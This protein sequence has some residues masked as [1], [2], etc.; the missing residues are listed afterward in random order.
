MV[1][2]GVVW[3]GV[4]GLRAR[5]CPS[6]SRPVVGITGITHTIK[7]LDYPE[8]R[9]DMGEKGHTYGTLDVSRLNERLGSPTLIVLVVSSHG[10][11]RIL[12]IELDTFSA[13]NLILF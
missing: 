3:C 5:N 7:R 12:R 8:L 13:L 9:S 2:C 11:G 1:W 4:V 6:T 10:P